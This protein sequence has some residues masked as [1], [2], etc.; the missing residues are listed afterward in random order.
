M[1]Y[2]E[3]QMELL[4]WYGYWAVWKDGRRGR[5]SASDMDWRLKLRTVLSA[6]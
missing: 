5:C 3:P 6:S 1:Y 2:S 4:K